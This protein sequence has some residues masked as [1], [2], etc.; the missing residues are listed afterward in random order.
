MIYSTII[1][2]YM[3][4]GSHLYTIEGRCLAAGKICRCPA[5]VKKNS[6][7]YWNIKN[8]SDHAIIIIKRIYNYLIIKANKY[9]S[10]IIENI[11]MIIGKIHAYNM[12]LN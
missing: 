12:Y 11:I 4:S 10:H 3:R 6:F 9:L 2:T 5:L 1:Q 8:V 7:A